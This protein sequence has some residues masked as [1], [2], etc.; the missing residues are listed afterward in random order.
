M[1]CSKDKCVILFN[2]Y[3]HSVEYSTPSSLISQMRKLGFGEMGVKV[4]DP[5]SRARTQTQAVS[6]QRLGA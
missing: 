2:P 3:N 1:W 6:L 5:D 4:L